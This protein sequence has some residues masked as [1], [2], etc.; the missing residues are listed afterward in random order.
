VDYPRGGSNSEVREV[1]A[2]FCGL[3]QAFTGSRAAQLAGI[4]FAKTHISEGLN[5]KLAR[6]NFGNRQYRSFNE[7]RKR[8]QQIAR[9]LPTKRNC[10]KAG[11]FISGL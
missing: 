6:P 8:D 1:T 2:W 7:E 5:F 10:S 9:S 4:A 3:G 11:L